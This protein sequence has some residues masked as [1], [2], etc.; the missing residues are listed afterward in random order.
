MSRISLVL[1]MILSMTGCHVFEKDY[2]ERLGRLVEV[3]EVMGSTGEETSATQPASASQPA[4][5]AP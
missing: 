3:S 4:S 1:V 2:M 5:E